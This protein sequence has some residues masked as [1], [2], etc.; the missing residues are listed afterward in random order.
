M[1]KPLTAHT[2]LYR[3]ATSGKHS[4]N[5]VVAF[6]THTILRAFPMRDDIALVRTN[7]DERMRHMG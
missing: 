3:E 6:V 7:S 5:N 2:A 1:K 4:L